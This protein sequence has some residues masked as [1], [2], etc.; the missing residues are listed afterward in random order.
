[1]SRRDVKLFHENTNHKLE[2]NMI[3]AYQNA[4]KINTEVRKHIKMVVDQ[5]EMCRQT[6]KTKPLPKATLPKVTDFNQVVAVDLAFQGK[7]PILWIVNMFTWFLGVMD[8]K[9]W[10]MSHKS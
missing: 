8:N 5:C 9:F 1:M 6:G 2:E 7:M 10:L 3:Y 4:G